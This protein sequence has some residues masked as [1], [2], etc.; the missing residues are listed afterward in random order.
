ML[1]SF[2]DIYTWGRGDYGQLGHGNH[3]S[4]DV[5]TLLQALDQRTQA[6]WLSGGA[7][8]M[9]AVTYSGAQFTC[10]TGT[11]VRVLTQKAALTLFMMAGTSS[12]THERAHVL[13][14]LVRKYKY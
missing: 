7:D 14:L 10:F 13:A 5:P 8:F 12:G 1:T 2:G 3:I 6:S 9:M 11:K 4:K